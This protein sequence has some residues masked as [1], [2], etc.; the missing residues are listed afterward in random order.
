MPAIFPS[1]FAHFSL[2]VVN[3]RSLLRRL[4]TLLSQQATLLASN[5]AFK[6]QAES[7][8]EAAKKYM[9]END[10]LKKEAAVGGIKLDG[11]D[12]EV[13]VQEENRSLKAD[14]KKLKDELASN[15]QKLEKA[16]NEVL[17]MR[18]QSEGLTKE[19]DRLLEEHAKLQAAVDGPVDKKQE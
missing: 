12:T 5:E 9:E 2:F 13:K 10:Q 8:S 15:K 14:V 18:K 1:S 19:Y 6:K 16:E 3:N 17:A 7:A 11:R 4:V